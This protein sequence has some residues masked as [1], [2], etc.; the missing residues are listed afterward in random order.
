MMGPG[1]VLPL[2]KTA[3]VNWHRYGS[4]R[5]GDLLDQFAATS[6][7]ETQ[8]NLCHQMQQAFLEEWPAIPL[9]PGPRWGAC[10]TKEFVGVPSEDDPYALLSPG[11]FSEKLLVETTLEERADD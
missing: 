2:G 3:A 11:A 8:M 1:L 9:Y 10:S 5:V 7:E 4:E 6:D